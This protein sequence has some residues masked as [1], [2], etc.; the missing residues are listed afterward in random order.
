MIVC[1]AP[2][3]SVMLVLSGSL[4][5][6]TGGSVRGEENGSGEMKKEE[7]KNGEK[8]EGKREG[9]IC[10]NNKSKDTDIS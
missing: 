10:D 2:L 5:V 8:R 3:L 4:S 6:I 7:K 9:R 1:E